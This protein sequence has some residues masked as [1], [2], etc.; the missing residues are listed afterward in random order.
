MSDL[1][2]RASL[3]NP[4]NRS[5]RGRPTGYDPKYAKI[6]FGLCV[7]DKAITLKQ[8]AYIFNVSQVTISDWLKN[9]SDFSDAVR[10]GRKQADAKVVS[11]LYERAIGYTHDEEKVFQNNGKIV[12]HTTK[13]HYPPDVKAAVSWLQVRQPELF[14]VLGNGEPPKT[15]NNNTQ[16]NLIGVVDSLKQ[17]GLGQRFLEAIQPAIQGAQPPKLPNDPKTKSIDGIEISKNALVE[18]ELIPDDNGQEQNLSGE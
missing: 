14:A 1:K 4:A 3:I 7:L 12:T 2:K 8:L 18:G 15:I 5:R 13:K 11:K 16:V 10:E 9:N 6:A 17:T